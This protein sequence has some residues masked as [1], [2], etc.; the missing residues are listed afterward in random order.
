MKIASKDLCTFT[1]VYRAIYMGPCHRSYI[2]L[3]RKFQTSEM[4][5]KWS[6]LSKLSD[7]KFSHYPDGRYIFFHLYK[8]PPVRDT[9]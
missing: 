7:I 9:Y 1:G 4:L 5:D 8:N 3:I 2:L 6:P